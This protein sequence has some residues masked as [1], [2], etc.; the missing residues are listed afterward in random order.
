MGVRIIIF[1]KNQLG[2]YTLMV[3]LN[4]KPFLLGM[5]YEQLFTPPISKLSQQP[6]FKYS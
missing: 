1:E 3:L 4:K 5:T 6:S 2:P